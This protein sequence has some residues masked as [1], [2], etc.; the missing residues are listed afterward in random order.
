M[1]HFG[2]E[3][4]ADFE[5]QAVSVQRRKAMQQHLDSGC[6][7]CKDSWVMWQGVIEIAEKEKSCEPPAYLVRAA[8]S[9]Y[10]LVRPL[11]N[12]TWTT[13]IAELMFDSFR[14]PLVAGVRS[15]SAAPRQMLYKSGGMTV[16]IRWEPEPGTNRL[17]LV[18]QLLN[19]V[20][21]DRIPKNVTVVLRAGSDHFASAT[22]NEFGEFH[23]EVDA[24]EKSQ[25]G[26]EVGDQFQIIL[27]HPELRV[28]P[29]GLAKA[30]GMN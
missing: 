30:R 17:S 2:T 28:T 29:R 27:P 26:I 14:Q 19:S 4:W 11:K 1:R 7:P 10:E 23:F 24:R 13:Q 18:G 15:G 3:E 6:K 9:S 21:P 16:D 20:E 22:T 12:T 25:I 5:R 8:K